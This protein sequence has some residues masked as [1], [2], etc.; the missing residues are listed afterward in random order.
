[1]ITS[2]VLSEEDNTQ[3]EQEF[4]TSLAQMDNYIKNLEEQF[5][6]TKSSE[7][8]IQ[9]LL[10]EPTSLDQCGTRRTNLEKVRQLL[11]EKIDEFKI[12]E[13][14]SEDKWFRKMD[15]MVA[16][17]N[18]TRNNSLQIQILGKK[19][20]HYIAKVDQELHV[21]ENASSLRREIHI[22]RE[23]AETLK[24]TLQSCD[25]RNDLEVRSLVAYANQWL[26]DQK[27][28]SVESGDKKGN[29]F[30]VLV[31]HDSRNLRETRQRLLVLLGYQ[32]KLQ[33]D[34]SVAKNGKEA[35]CLHLAGASF[36]MILM[37]DLMPFMNGLET[38][39]ML[40]KIGV[41]SQIVGVTHEF[42][43]VAFMDSGSDSCI[44]KPLTL[45]KLAAVFS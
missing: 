33:M 22:D 40:R 28:Q 18:L 39:K 5:T 12:K 26:N 10:T 4:R 24:L 7:A 42:K 41:E 1:M 29:N 27:I 23:Q 6:D 20:D 17:F 21:L 30:S 45:E 14:D 25:R 3:V 11:I 44:I 8:K 31:V 36:D 16:W 37:D 13:V 43:R 9:A 19:L 38:I 32:K 34:V 15:A 35:V 2:Q